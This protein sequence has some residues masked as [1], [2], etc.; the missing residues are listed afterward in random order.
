[1]NSGLKTTLPLMALALTLLGVDIKT[2]LDSG[3]AMASDLPGPNASALSLYIVT[4]SP[5]KEWSLWP[6]KGELYKGS[7]PHG[8]L[9]T[10]YVN[11]IALEAIKAN[12]PMK[13]GAIIAKENYTPDKKFV[14]L[15]VMYK[16][17]GYNPRAG[18]WYWAKYD[19]NGMAQ[20]AGKVE[21][22][23]NCHGAAGGRDFLFSND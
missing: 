6:G 3:T 1:M 10:T 5:Y 7:E 14:A 23:I 9:L 19:A 4:E 12:R 15:T 21:G 22:C 8:A 20:N 16:I 11:D 13:P 2:G 18:D 17:D